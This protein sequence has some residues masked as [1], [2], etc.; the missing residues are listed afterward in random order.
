MICTILGIYDTDCT[1]PDI[2]NIAPLCRISVIYTLKNAASLATLAA[3]TLLS[4]VLAYWS[5]AWLAPP[6]VPR[7]PAAVVSS[8]SASAAAGLFRDVKS[9]PGV[10]AAGPSTIRLVGIV[11][12]SGGRRSGQ[13][14]L[15][16]DGKKTVAVLQGQD[17]EPGLRLAEVHVD[18][19]ILERNGARETLA[20]PEKPAK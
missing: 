4:V 16:L 13:A 17:V 20:W 1:L 6:A 10:T 12:P 7:A 19:I 15:R 14:V 18:H 2:L 8:G 3:L 9:G 5:W 11:A